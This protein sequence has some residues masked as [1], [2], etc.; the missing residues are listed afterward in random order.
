MKLVQ[1]S[2][3]LFSFSLA[4]CESAAV[5]MDAPVAADAPVDANLKSVVVTLV[6]P[7][8]DLAAAGLVFAY[9]DGDGAWQKAPAAVGGKITFQV[10]NDRYGFAFDCPD[11]T[12][13]QI[14][15]QYATQSTKPSVATDLG[16]CSAATVVVPPGS[17]TGTLQTIGERTHTI[18][19]G[20]RR[21][22]KTTAANEVSVP[23]SFTVPLTTADMI[24]S[25]RDAAGVYDRYAVE[26][27]VTVGAA[28]VT[29]Q[30]DFNALSTPDVVAQPTPA[31]GTSN[32]A[33]IYFTS[34]SRQTFF[35]SEPPFS[36]AAPPVAQRLP[37]DKFEVSL[38]HFAANGDASVGIDKVMASPQAVELPDNLLNLITLTAA[39]PGKV[40][41]G[42]QRLANPK[43]NYYSSASFSCGDQCGAFVFANFSQAWL[44]ASTSAT[45]TT[46]ELPIFGI[47]GLTNFAFVEMNAEIETG[48][49]PDVGYVYEFHSRSNQISTLRKPTSKGF[50]A[51]QQAARCHGRLAKRAICDAR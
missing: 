38:T 27:N 48:T 51:A 44:G 21:V 41:V 10:A 13:H 49:Y 28:P 1:L 16:F 8:A 26:R 12:D 5:P 19:F 50:A 45:W 17:I 40:K 7:P 47:S 9:Q 29:K 22:T 4:A 18:S 15:A 33:S 36:I 43:A 31:A 3:L 30:F 46:P 25:R 20:T 35:S 23:Y 24:L 42:W 34:T 6:D 32:F 14:N 2:P 11:G 37:T 39:G